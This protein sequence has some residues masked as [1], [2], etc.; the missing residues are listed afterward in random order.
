MSLFHVSTRLLVASALLLVLTSCGGP[1][2]QSPA[3]ARSAAAST[4]PDAH[5]VVNGVPITRQDMELAMAQ[6]GHKADTSL[7]GQKN[8][9]DKLIADELIAQEAAKLGLDSDSRYQENRARLEAQ[10]NAFKRDAL[11]QVYFREEIRNKAKPSAEAVRRHF[12]E[13]EQQVRTEVHVK[14][15]LR[16]S[17]AAIEADQAR[18]AAGESFDDVAASRFEGVALGERVP[19]DLGYMK[20]TQIPE[21][22]EE[23]VASLPDGGVSDILFNATGRFWLIQVVGRK[24]NAE[25]TFEQVAPVIAG[26]LEKQAIA[27]RQASLDKQRYK[28]ASI[29]ILPAAEQLLPLPSADSEED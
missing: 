20:S 3:P 16:K 24:V 1:A 25:L 26:L 27:E 17:R 22:W 6:G 12:D 7:A 11:G 29:E 13:N 18:L 21:V 28:A 10:T 2:A 9:L 14:Q 19:W 8:M 23:A 15:I 4:P 5:A